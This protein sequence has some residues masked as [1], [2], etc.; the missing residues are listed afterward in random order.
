LLVPQTHGTSE[1]GLYD[2]ATASLESGE[3]K[4]AGLFVTGRPGL[5]KFARHA[6]V[7]VA[8]LAMGIVFILD[9]IWVTIGCL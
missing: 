2:Q 4:P 3:L 6:D 5:L 7:I 8:Q 1:I 9:K